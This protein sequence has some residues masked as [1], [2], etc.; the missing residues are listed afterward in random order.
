MNIKTMKL[1][2]IF[3]SGFTSNNH[4]KSDF[5]NVVNNVFNQKNLKY[6]PVFTGNSNISLNNLWHDDLHLNNSGKG[7]ILFIF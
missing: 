7:I 1:K 6:G 3:F 2:K 4:G 5:I